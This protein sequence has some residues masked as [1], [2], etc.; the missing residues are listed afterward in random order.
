MMNCVGYGRSGPCLFWGISMAFVWWQCGKQQGPP[1]QDV[2]P[3]GYDVNLGHAE[4]NGILPTYMQQWM[5][6]LFSFCLYFHA[7]IQGIYLY[8]KSRDQFYYFPPERNNRNL[9][10]SFSEKR[11]RTPSH[12]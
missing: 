7:V 2:S 10:H 5:N 12:G 3:P 1:T 8:G 9:G 11:Q 4:Y 6:D